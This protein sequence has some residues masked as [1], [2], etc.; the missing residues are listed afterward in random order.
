[1]RATLAEA[2]VAGERDREW[3]GEEDECEQEKKKKKKKKK[4]G[5][6]DLLFCYQRMANALKDP[7]AWA[8]SL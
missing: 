4:V 3:G 1:M 7:V 2:R 8:T 5:S 6:A